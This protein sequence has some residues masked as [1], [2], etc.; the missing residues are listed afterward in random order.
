M[1]MGAADSTSTPLARDQFPIADRYRYLNHALVA[2]LPR[3]A[4]DAIADDARR[5]SL[6]ASLAYRARDERSEAV[7]DTA[8]A[9]MGVA[10]EDVAFVKNTTEGLAFV[11]GGL[12][13][14]PGD[15]VIVPAGEYPSTLFPWLALAHRGVVVDRVEPLGAGASLP[16]ESFA[17]ALE[18]GRG[19]VRVVALSWVQFGRGW[20]TDLAA[21]AQLCHSHG[22]LLCADVIQGLGVLPCRLADWGVDFAM[23][24]GHKWML[25]PEG[26][27]VF[28]VA[29]AHRHR[30]RVLEPGWA[31]VVD[32]DSDVPALDLADSAR[33]FEGGTANT[34]GIAGLG[35]SLDLLT[36]AGIEPVWAWVDGLC[37]RL[38]AGVTAAGAQVLSDRSPEGRSAIVSVAVPGVDPAAVV[39]RLAEAGVVVRARAGGVRF[40]PH[41]WNDASDIDAAVAVIAALVS[42][43]RSVPKR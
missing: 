32:R 37:D 38:V 43:G 31:S 13:W 14:R 17:A 21:L 42:C 34:T 12:D 23:A 11:A 39:A 4:V 7:R 6:E 3:D 40:G 35:A 26:V 33:R 5:C 2:P 41:A 24:D 10:A 9:L 28:Y 15:R 30:L 8:A 25:G 18:A 29:P 20:R 16:I 36:E 19:R 22:A 27:G 1:S